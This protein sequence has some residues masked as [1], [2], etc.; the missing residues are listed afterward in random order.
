MR[1]STLLTIIICFISVHAEEMHLKHLDT[2]NGLP[3]NKINTLHRDSD[4]F[5]WIGTSSGLCRYDGYTFKTYHP[6][7][8]AGTAIHDSYVESIEE[9]SSGR[10]WILLGTKY[11]VYDPVTDRL[12]SDI[13]PFLTTAGINEEPS[14]IHITP[15]KNMWVHLAGS[16][17]FRI[18]PDGKRADKVNDPEFAKAKVTDIISSPKTLITIDDRGTLRII[19][20]ES[21]KTVRR[22][23]SIAGSLPG[24]NTYIFTVVYDREGLVWIFNNEDL[25][26]YDIAAGRWLNDR[27]PDNG[28]RQLVK[29]LIQDH[30]G[31]LWLGRDHKGLESIE[32]HGE[33]SFR[34]L[35]VETDSHVTNTVTA[36]YEDEGGTLWIGTYKKGVFYHNKSANKFTLVPF[37]DVN[38]ILPSANDT[39]VWIGTDA[40][41]LIEWNPK[42]GSSRLFPNPTDGDNSPA[43]TSM[44]ELTDG[45]LLIGSFSRGL[46]QFKDGKFS[47]LQTGSRLDNFYSW[48]L[49]DAGD[50]R[51]W[52][53]TL[54]AG[55]MLLN[56][57]TLQTIVYDS[58]NSGLRSDFINAIAH[59]SNGTLYLATSRGVA[60][61]NPFTEKFSSIPG[62]DEAKINDLYMDSRSLLWIASTS[63]LKLYDTRRSKLYDVHTAQSPNGSSGFILG[64]QEDSRGDMWVTEGSRIICFSVKFDDKTGDLSYSSRTYDSSDGLQDCDFNQRSFALLPSGE[65]LVGGLYGINTF[66]P[67][68]IVHNRALPRV[69]FSD[70]TVGPHTIGVGD[71][72]DGKVLLSASPNHGGQLELWPSNTS[73]TVSLATDNYVHPEK[74]TYYYKLEGFDSDWMMAPPTT[75]RLNYTNLPPGKY[76]LLV[77]AVNS[78]G[79]ESVEPATMAIVMHPPFWASAWAKAIYSLLIILAIYA[80]YRIIRQR[81]RRRFN[82]KRKQDALIK[83][84]EINQL[85]FK[86]YTNVSHELRTPLTLIVAPLENMIKETTD[87]HQ[88]SRLNI[89]R[90]NALRL[91]MLV[92][93]LLDFRKNE[94]T[95]LTLHLSEGE[96]VSFVRNTCQS[97]ANLSER[98]NISLNFDTSI[99][100]LNCKFDDDKLSKTINN[101]LA[102]AF[103]FT[104]EGGSVTVGIRSSRSKVTISIADTG[105][106]ISDADKAHI[107][108][109]FYQAEGSPK[110]SSMTGNGIGL[111]MAYEYIR[112]HNGTISVADNPGG[113]TVFIIELPLV[114]STVPVNQTAANTIATTITAKQEEPQPLSDSTGGKERDS[115]TSGQ[116][117]V[118][119]SDN[120][121]K[122]NPANRQL[123][124][125]Q[126]QSDKP[127]A[128]VVDDSDDMLEF[129]RDGLRHDFHVITAGSGAEA[130][131]LLDSIRPAIVL[132]DLMMP[133]ID[134]I[135]LC[136]RIKATAAHSSTPVIILT[137]KHDINA[138]LEGFTIGADDYITKP[139]N[140]ELLLLKMKKLVSLTRK[141]GTSLINPDP[142]SIKI[143][144]LDEKIVEKAVKYVVTNIKRPELSVEELSSHLGMSRVHLYKK[145]KATTGKTPVE[146]IRLIRLKR[147]AQM[148][149][150]SQLNVS[151]IAFQLGFNNPKYFSKYFK[152]EFGVLPSVYQDKEA[153]ATNYPV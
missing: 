137:A 97:F 150:E 20:R 121:T 92:N 10:L 47:M 146:F 11:M 148:L 29:I 25:W 70:I 36:L 14:L 108:E 8:S 118:T 91:L 111:S 110:D 86:F 116:T 9:D 62:I 130:I 39:H 127:T 30:S 5:L 37:P 115:Q 44:L 139:F 58:S 133:G 40:D 98:K 119:N 96:M 147:G 112:L 93:Q 61:F 41:G 50:G 34:R 140:V 32:K 27:L 12:N 143:T 43:I 113:G 89:M 122:T 80:T 17:L 142:G 18:S 99:P 46:R 71:K 16:G 135:E 75:N 2:N 76:R 59:G 42:D 79:Y 103:K 24:S 22:D 106:G 77:K 87:E 88:L 104:P 4:G 35:P 125:N 94:V 153:K 26:L 55:L 151:E 109:R 21:L 15:D 95:G 53:G 3:N 128:L 48:A 73:F 114:T 141:N 38:C 13:R 126:D 90:K 1:L 117:S 72:I 51:I 102:N 65:M 131:R 19:D 68:R 63:G 132:T 134:G 28:K 31:D 107:F 23:T 57:A 66:S 60:T 136:R 81:E 123:P 85:K 149:R 56:P 144:P 124:T 64:L 83:Q 138:K 69:I 45:S 129:L 49:S 101:L 67:D 7:D 152:E 100:E 120:R 82:L 145:L 33:I 74:T 52:V 78:D 84:E 54:G 105:I 6:S